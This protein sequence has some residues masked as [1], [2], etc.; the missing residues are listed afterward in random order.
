MTM[1][2]PSVFDFTPRTTVIRTV[3]ASWGAGGFI[4]ILILA[5]Q[6][7][8]P[9]ALD[10]LRHELTT[11]H[12]LVLV[13][14]SIF[15]AYSEGYRGFQCAYSPRL[16]ARALWLYRHADWRQC[17]VA[18]LLCMG[19]LQAP[20][21]RMISAWVLTAMITVLVI[22]FRSLPQPWRGILDAGVIVGLGWGLLATL[23][24]CVQAMLKPG[25]TVDPEVC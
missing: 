25:S 20:R 1:S 11:T 13:S 18:P 17:L 5:L 23:A 6:K 2:G 21:R 15:M 8:T 3:A 12:W 10:A 4:A 7:L 16:A 14:N 24:A 9:V 19:F 22:V